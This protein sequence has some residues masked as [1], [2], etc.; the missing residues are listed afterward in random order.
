M[1]QDTTERCD[2]GHLHVVMSQ[3]Y[4]DFCGGLI[5]TEQPGRLDIFGRGEASEMKLVYPASDGRVY[6]T[7]TYSPALQQPKRLKFDFCCVSHVL[8]FF[9]DARFG[10]M[11]QDEIEISLPYGALLMSAVQEPP[12]EEPTAQ[13]PEDAARGEGA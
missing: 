6:I 3:V 8:R 5:V 10:Q 13:R 12:V 11:L 9:R 1:R 2:R 4:C 7:V